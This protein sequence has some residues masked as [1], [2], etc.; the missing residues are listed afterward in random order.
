MLVVSQVNGLMRTCGTYLPTYVVESDQNVP[1]HLP[2][3]PCK[4]KKKK[5]KK[6]KGLVDVADMCMCMFVCV[7]TKRWW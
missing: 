3:K 6:K 1:R 2:Y 5:R 4:K 7:H